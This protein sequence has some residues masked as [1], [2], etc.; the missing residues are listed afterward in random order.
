MVNNSSYKRWNRPSQNSKTKQGYYKIA[1]KNKYIGDPELII[2]RSSWE[3]KFCRYC[4]MSPS[5]LKWSSEPIQI[6]YYDRISKLEECAK[7]GL[8]PNDPSN[9]EIKNYNTDFWFETDKGDGITEKTFVEIKP[10]HELKKPI[11]P[12]RDATLKEEK[13]FNEAARRFLIN[14]AKFAAMKEWAKRNNCLFYVYTEDI[15]EKILGRF[16]YENDY[17]QK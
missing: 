10:A 5:V 12:N 8:N 15:L 16:W 9:W 3:R 14:E 1:N 17:E 6:P 7:F 13:R 2:Y 11:P 4:D